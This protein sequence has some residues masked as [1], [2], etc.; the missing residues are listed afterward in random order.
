MWD[1]NTDPASRKSFAYNSIKTK[2]SLLPLKDIMI[3]RISSIDLP[4]C[5]RVAL[6]I[7]LDYQENS[8]REQFGHLDLWGHMARYY[9]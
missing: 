6:V 7:T 2:P 5:L 8:I 1:N 4:T 9:Y 3:S